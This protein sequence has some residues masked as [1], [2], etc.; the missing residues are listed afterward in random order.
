MAKL[1]IGSSSGDPIPALVLF[2]TQRL[3]NRGSDQCQLLELGRRH[4]D[5]DLGLSDAADIMA[6]VRRWASGAANSGSAPVLADNPALRNLVAAAWAIRRGVLSQCADL[7]RSAD[8]GEAAGCH[9]T[10]NAGGRDIV[11]RRGGDRA[12]DYKRTLGGLYDADRRGGG[13]SRPCW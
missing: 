1:S 11:S 12:G 7:F 13:A 8:Q 2:D 6:P 3:Q 4:R 9:S 10:A 5:C